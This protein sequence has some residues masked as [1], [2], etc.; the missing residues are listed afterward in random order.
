MVKG[1]LLLQGGAV[2]QQQ[3]IRFVRQRGVAVI[4]LPA[5]LTA[6]RKRRWLA[7]PQLGEAS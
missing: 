7:S 1:R 6:R 2:D 3:F 5:G 4:A